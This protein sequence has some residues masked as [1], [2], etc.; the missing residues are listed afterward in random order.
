MID[1][2]AHKVRLGRFS[3][4]GRVDRQEASRRVHIAFGKVKQGVIRYTIPII[5]KKTYFRT[6]STGT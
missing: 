6:S 1:L 3:G 5:Q 4:Q 2:T